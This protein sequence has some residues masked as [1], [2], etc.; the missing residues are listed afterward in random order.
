MIR[1]ILSI[2]I[3]ALGGCGNS[4]GNQPDVRPERVTRVIVGEPTLRNIDYVLTALGSVE[5]IHHPTI[6][7]ETS[8]Q[9]ISVGVSEGQAVSAAQLLVSIN[10]TLHNIQSAKAQAEL[11]RQEVLLNNQARV[12]ERLLRLAQSQSVSKDQLEDQQAQLAMLKA[13]RD[14]AKKQWEQAQHMESKTRV[15][16]PQSGLIARRH[17]SLGDYVAMGTPLFDLVSVDRLRARLA[18]PEQDTS[19]ISIGKKVRLTSPA[20]PDIVAIGEVAGINPQINIRNRSIEV[21]VEFD[22]P[23]GWLPGASVDATLVTEQHTA[24]LTL[25]LMSV[26]KRGGTDV[27]YVADKNRAV[28]HRVDLGWREGEWVEVLSELKPNT[29]VVVDGAALLTDGSLLSIA[30]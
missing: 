7:A 16:A 19:S 13:Q 29:Q 8:G 25:P 6:A 28:A 5:S 18:F 21:T 17:I 9:I 2:L 3:V 12:V 26:V 27:I 15:L 20:A 1:V 22:N 4:D 24:A 14:G 11:R 10:N 30:E 23:G